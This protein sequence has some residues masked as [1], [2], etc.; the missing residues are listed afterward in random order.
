M[1]NILNQIE[2]EF[3]NIEAVREKLFEPKLIQLHTGN[4]MFDSPD[5]FGVYKNSG[6][7]ALG[8]VGSRYSPMNLEIMLESIVQSVMSCDVNID[9]STLDFKEYHGGKKVAFTLALPTT[10]IK[11][12][13]MVGDVIK[14]RLEFR[15]GFDGL[16]KTS[17]TEYMYRL[18]CSNGASSP[19]SQV[20]SFKNTTNNHMKI[21][22]L[23]G[24]IANTI[25]KNNEF[26]IDFGRMA[27]LRIDSNELD[28]FIKKV[29]GLSAKDYKTMSAQSRTMLDAINRSVA[30]EMSNT[31]DNLFSVV[32][33]FTR[34]ATHDKSNKNEEKLL[35]SS[36][37]TLVQNTFSV[38]LAQLN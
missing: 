26:L 36:V 3:D 19:H 9:L 29:T 17:I 16:T 7:A 27:S 38:A 10:E 13:P 18:W 25:E 34:Y 6:G 12:S 1:S 14:R 30:I 22:N 37:N 20:M 11:G 35:Y 28:S 8:V 2:R 23:C 4:E 21:Y 24:Y 15:T 31:G 33:G 32:N 5:A